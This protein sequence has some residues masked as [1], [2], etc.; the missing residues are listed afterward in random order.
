MPGSGD[1]AGAWD[2]GPLLLCG[3][4]RVFRIPIRVARSDLEARAEALEGAGLA[5]TRAAAREWRM[6]AVAAV[7]VLSPQT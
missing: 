2:T 7:V 5:R 6:A 1:A 4:Q 3:C